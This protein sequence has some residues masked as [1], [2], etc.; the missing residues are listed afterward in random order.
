MANFNNFPFEI[1]SYIWELTVEPR[2]VEVRVLW[3]GRTPRV[4]STTPIPAPLQVC[5][6]ARNLSLY[7]Q[8]FSELSTGR[9]YVWLNLDIDMVSIGTV[10]LDAFNEVAPM[11][12]RL[13]FERENQESWYH[14]ESRKIRNFVNVEEI[15]VICLDGFENWGGATYE[16]C[17]PCALENIV[18]FDLVDSLVMR[19]VELEE[20]YE[21]WYEAQHR[22]VVENDEREAQDLFAELTTIE[23]WI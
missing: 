23:Q 7:K 10:R 13:K 20:K 18:F 1:R 22:R 19:G 15:H 21:E 6:E 8:V 11:I 9:R 4:A 17:W 3:G 12:K 16:H 5:R 14:F 2:T